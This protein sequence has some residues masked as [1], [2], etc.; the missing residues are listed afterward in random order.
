M[1]RIRRNPA[2]TML[3]FASAQLSS[4]MII[5]DLKIMRGPKSAL[6]AA[7]PSVKQLDRDGKPVLVNGKPTWRDFIEFRDKATRD[8][9]STLVID[10]VRD[11]HPGDLEEG[12]R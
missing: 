3:G 9:F 7:M 2:G 11:A 4:G 10:L 6:W 5:N 12:A 1:L 8:R